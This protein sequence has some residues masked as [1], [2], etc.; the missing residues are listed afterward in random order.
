MRSSLLG[1][2]KPIFKNYQFFI[3][4]KLFLPS[5]R[6]KTKSAQGQQK[7]RSNQKV[8]ENKPALKL[9]IMLKTK[10]VGLNFGI[11]YLTEP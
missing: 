11:E 9:N 7:E 2:F 1:G 4:F 3:V 6:T 8:E 5:K 10:C